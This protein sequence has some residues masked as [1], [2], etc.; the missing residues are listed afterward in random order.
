MDTFLFTW[1]DVALLVSGALLLLAV[2]ATLAWR[3]PRS[4]EGIPDSEMP[5]RDG[6]PAGS[7]QPRGEQVPVSR[8]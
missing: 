4:A 2:G 8:H 1:L 5:R 3:V 7:P 6:L